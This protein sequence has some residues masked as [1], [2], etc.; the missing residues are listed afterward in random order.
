MLNVLY[1][2]DF[3]ILVQPT[4]IHS[5]SKWISN[6]NKNTVQLQ[7]RLVVKSDVL[8]FQNVLAF[9]KQLKGGFVFN[10][11]QRWEITLNI[12]SKFHRKLLAESAT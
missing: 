4:N 10:T 9:V 5:D 8:F 2:L 11:L 3:L 6:V 7:V 12:H 1:V